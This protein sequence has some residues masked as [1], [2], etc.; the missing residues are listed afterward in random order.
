MSKLWL[1]LSVVNFHF[2]S[3]DKCVEQW[4]YPGTFPYRKTI[5]I[6]IIIV[7]IIIVIIVVVA[8]SPAGH[9]IVPLKKGADWR[10]SSE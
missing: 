3:P 8:V 9:C 10:N 2:L 5:I 7:A 6:S 1:L 4:L